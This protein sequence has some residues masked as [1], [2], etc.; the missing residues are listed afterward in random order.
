MRI[1]MKKNEINIPIWHKM[2]MTIAEAAQYSNIGENTLLELMKSKNAHFSFRVGR[3]H[4]INRELFE[5]YI[6][7]CCQ[8]GF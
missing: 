5:E 3:K 8:H 1:K 4:L 7:D 2:N 6:K